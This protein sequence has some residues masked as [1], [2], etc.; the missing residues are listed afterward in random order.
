MKKKKS[1]NCKTTSK[2]NYMLLGYQQE[3]KEIVELKIFEKIM[4]EK[5]PKLTAKTKS[6]NNNSENTKQDKH[7]KI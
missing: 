1:K 6:Q 4:E 3:K 5:F 7:Q 2:C